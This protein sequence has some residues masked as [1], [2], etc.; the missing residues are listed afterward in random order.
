PVFIRETRLFAG[1]VELTDPLVPD[2]GTEWR[3]DPHASRSF[4]KAID[5]QRSPSASLVKMNSNKGL[6]FDTE[7]ECVMRCEWRGQLFDVRQSLYV[8]VRDT[9]NTIVPLV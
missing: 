6:V 3:V 4:G 7:I 8:R 9:N 5:Q 2:D 1:K